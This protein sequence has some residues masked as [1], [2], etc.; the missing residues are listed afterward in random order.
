VEIEI[1][2]GD[3]DEARSLREWLVGEDELRGRVRLRETA[4]PPGALGSLT[5]LI[6]VTLAQGGGITALTTVLVTWLRQRRGDLTVRVRHKDTEIEVVG[7]KVRGLDAAGLRQEADRLARLIGEA[8]RS[9]ADD[10][11]TR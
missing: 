8:D 5:E 2:V 6:V 9:D 10:P 4:P 11:A 1:W 7:T 3:G